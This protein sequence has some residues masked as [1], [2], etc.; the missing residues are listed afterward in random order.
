MLF[1]SGNVRQTYANSFA[2]VQN[3]VKSLSDEESLLETLDLV[4]HISTVLY[5]EN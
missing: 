2:Q 1:S 4:L 5:K 3:I